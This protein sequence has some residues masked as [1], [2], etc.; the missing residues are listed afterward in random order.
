ML[1]KH[2]K[3][4]QSNDPAAWAATVT[5]ILNKWNAAHTVDN[6]YGLVAANAYITPAQA[7]RIADTLF[8]RRAK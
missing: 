2:H 3:N 7:E 8:A 6:F 5:E 1:R 4:L